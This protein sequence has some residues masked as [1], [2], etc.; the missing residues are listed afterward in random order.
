[1]KTVFFFEMSN[2]AYKTAQNSTA[3]PTDML[4]LCTR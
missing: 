2:E 4:Y 3:A 1:M